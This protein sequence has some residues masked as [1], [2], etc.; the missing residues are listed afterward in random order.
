M[1]T[2]KT[3]AANEI[4]EMNTT[5]WAQGTTRAVYVLELGDV[6]V[7]AAVAALADFIE[8]ISLGNTYQKF[9]SYLVPREWD[10]ERRLK[11]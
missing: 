10:G 8:D 9:F 5:F 11:P 4:I 1:G 2:V 6:S 3:V 7:A